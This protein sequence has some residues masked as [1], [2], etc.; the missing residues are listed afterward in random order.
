MPNDIWKKK[1]LEL[2]DRQDRLQANCSTQV[3]LLKRG[4]IRSSLA[5]EG[6][7]E[8]LDHQLHMLRT[9]LRKDASSADLAEHIALLEKAVLKYEEK[10]QQRKHD[11]NMTLAQAVQQLMQLQPPKEIQKALRDF[12]KNLQK[13]LAQPHN[14]HKVLHQLIALQER[15]IT[16]TATQKPQ[17]AATPGLLARLFKKVESP[18]AQSETQITPP[19]EAAISTLQQPA[20]DD[21]APLPNAASSEHATPAQ[22]ESD[23]Y[24]LPLLTEASYSSVALH[25]HS[26]LTRL[27]NDLPISANHEQQVIAMQSRINQGLNWYEL[28]P[29]LDEL[30]TL[31][32][33]IAYGAENDLEQY[34]LQLNQR[35]ASFHDNLQTTSSNYTESAEDAQKFGADLKQHVT[36]FQGDVATS[37]DLT[38]LK[39]R[40]DSRLDR[41]LST[42]QAYQEKR[43][44][45][46]AAMLERFQALAEHSKQ[47]EKETQQLSAKLE[48]QRQQALLDPLTG[49]ANRAAWNARSEL[50]YARIQRN[51]SSLLLSII[52]IDHFKRIN[53]TY[54]HLAGDK[55]LKII[56]QEL[57]KRLR[58]T[59]F[60]ARFGGEEYVILLPE[61]PLQNG[62][63]LLDSLRLAI[64]ACPFHFRGDP[65]TITFSAGIGQV[66][67]DETLEQAFER[68]DQALYSAKKIG[69]NTVQKAIAPISQMPEQP[70]SERNTV[71]SK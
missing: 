54:G 70:T 62:Y 10:L 49:L 66:T 33:A 69:R 55:V 60:I 8:Q 3:D 52:D 34:L 63:E 28:A 36:D 6:N 64:E 1:Y 44:H 20:A 41:F 29:L 14:L 23:H 37:H 40:V 47:M 48:E 39:K 58:K 45:Q 59:D 25:I 4:L 18:A 53:D 7:D 46:D 17:A 51:H 11:L 2:L 61:T 13:Q 21:L 42:L 32:L 65:V 24:A 68:I 30:S 26:T 57:K 71:D 31:I 19:A 9:L 16:A 43:E 12:E 50:E 5:A 56:A 27:L 15:S 38:E 35:L 22:V 67:P